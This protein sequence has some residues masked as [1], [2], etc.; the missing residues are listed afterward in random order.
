MRLLALRVFHTLVVRVRTA[1]SF[2][3]RAVLDRKAFFR[4]RFQ[5]DTASLHDAVALPQSVSLHRLLQRLDGPHARTR[6]RVLGRVRRIVNVHD[7]LAFARVVLELDRASRVVVAVGQGLVA[8]YC[9]ARD[10]EALQNAQEQQDE[11][12]Q[13]LSHGGRIAWSKYEVLLV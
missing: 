4:A 7:R 2:S 9:R 12:R 3:I 8:V 10:E 6:T 11:F 13:H 5:R 1:D